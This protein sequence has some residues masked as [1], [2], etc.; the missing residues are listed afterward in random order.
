MNSLEIILPLHNPTAALQRTAG[1][2]A[3][4]TDRGFSVLISDNFSATGGEFITGA[5]EQLRAAG[6]PARRVQPPAELGRVEHWNWMHYESNADWL[7]PLSAG[8][9]LEPGYV[10]R[11]REG[12]GANPDCRYVS[13]NYVLHRGHAAPRRMSSAWA[14]R[15]HPAP[16]LRQNV[17]AFGKLFGPPGAAAYEKTAFTAIGG[18][19]T[20][21]RIRAA[22]LVFHT[23]ALRFGALGL[24]EP[25]C[26]CASLDDDL[27]SGAPSRKPASQEAFTQYFMLAYYAWTENVS[28]PRFQFLKLLAREAR[29]RCFGSEA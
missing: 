24:A 16:E 19:P 22:S 10:A 20:T 28:L 18:F 6:I 7:K 17:P 13:C 15:F 5:V 26:H 25:L 12:I 8:N 29:A 4:Q 21:L 23:L 1:S 27:A 11:L 14:G 3:A 9:W 2:L